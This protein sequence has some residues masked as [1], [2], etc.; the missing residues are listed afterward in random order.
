MKLQIEGVEVFAVPL[1]TLWTALNDP[2]VLTECIPGCQR[3][4]EIGPDAYALEMQLKVAAVGGAFTGEISLSEKVA[5]SSCVIAVSGAGT[6]GQGVGVARFKID[7][8]D[9]ASSRLVYG[10][11]GEIAG[12]VAG[13]G[14]RILGA[15]SKHLI[16]QF[17]TALRAEL[18]TAPSEAA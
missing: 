7:C 8:V 1:E 4:V 14:Q 11:E 10:G 6:L 5:P 3:M 15:V 18:A 16:K 9:A 13:V 17:F 2:L 12:L